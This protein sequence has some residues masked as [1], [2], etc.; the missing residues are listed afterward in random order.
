MVDRR[1]GRRSVLGDEASGLSARR[2]ATPPS[3]LIGVRR[4]ASPSGYANGTAR[5]VPLVRYRSGVRELSVDGMFACDVSIGEA[6][7]PSDGRRIGSGDGTD[8]P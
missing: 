1:D 3:P 5:C 8:A 6:D 7:I 2:C 4:E